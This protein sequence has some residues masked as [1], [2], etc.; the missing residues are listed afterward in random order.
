[1]SYE[2]FLTTAKISIDQFNDYFKGRAHYH[3]EQGQ[4]FYEHNSTGVYFSFDCND[5]PAED[6]D[7]LDYN[8]SFTINYYRPHYFALEAEPEV[9][10]YVDH[11]DSSISAT[12]S[13]G[14]R[15]GPYSR[16]V[17]FTQLELWQSI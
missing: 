14:M 4:A 2:L 15:D 17:F 12:Q 10:A 16:E 11:F 8:V 7:G 6:K 3:V 13:E 5:S 1:M 9:R